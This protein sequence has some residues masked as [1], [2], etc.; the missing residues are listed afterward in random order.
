MLGSLTSLTGGGGLTGGSSGPA[1]SGNTSNT[2]NNSGFTVGGMNFGS[3]NGIPWWGIALAALIA[4][5][6]L[7]RK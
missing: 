2:T 4:L 7:T 1:K 5:Y 6:V 3:N